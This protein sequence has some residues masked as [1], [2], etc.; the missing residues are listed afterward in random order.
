MFRA[1]EKRRRARRA[2]TF[3]WYAMRMAAP[4]LAIF[5][6]ESEPAPST[7]APTGFFRVESIRAQRG[8]TL[9][10]ARRLQLH[11]GTHTLPAGAHASYVLR[12][13]TGHVRYVTDTEKVALAVHPP[14]LER[15]VAT[16]ASLIP[17]RKSDAWWE[18]SQDK[19]RAILEERSHHIAIGLEYVPAI[20]RRLYH[21]R[22]LGE[23]FD[24]LTWFEYA[25]SDAGRFAELLKALRATEEWKYV[26]REVQVDLTR[27]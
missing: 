2:R 1:R 23:S 4:I 16:R 5:A 6:F 8:A 11:E 7:I 20:A 26:E 19:R 14:L 10:D 22:E 12:G 17:I 3:A 25:P 21:A 15:P 24:F 27:L 13:S 18:L 9:P